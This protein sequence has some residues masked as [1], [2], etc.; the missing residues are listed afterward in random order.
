M[1]I[2]RGDNSAKGYISNRHKKLPF[3]P[4]FT[5]INPPRCKQLGD[6]KSIHT[7]RHLQKTPFEPSKVSAAFQY[8]S[9]PPECH[10]SWPAS[11]PSLAKY[12]YF[13]QPERWAPAFSLHMDG[14]NSNLLN[15]IPPL[16][17][18]RRQRQLKLSHPRDYHPQLTGYSVTGPTCPGVT[19]GLLS[20]VQ[21]NPK[22][23]KD[24]IPHCSSDCWM[25]AASSGTSL[26]A[27]LRLLANQNL[28]TYLLSKLITS[29]NLL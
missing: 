12:Q 14:P 17:R 20:A 16:N 7:K 23:S 21:A 27:I 4:P 1:Q 11:C 3:F 28:L 5:I 9:L 10:H 13:H 18:A 15:K 29:Y 24:Q 6:N 8:Q 25:P 19:G 22:L 26:A 2:S